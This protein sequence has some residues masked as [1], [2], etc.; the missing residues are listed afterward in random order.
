MR[1]GLIITPFPRLKSDYALT[2]LKKVLFGLQ[3]AFLS[4]PKRLQHFS[5]LL[6][7]ELETY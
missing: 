2:I 5:P 3:V 6:V 1:R 4:S 7:K